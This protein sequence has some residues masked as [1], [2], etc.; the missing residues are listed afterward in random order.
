[1][2][3]FNGE[4]GR[5]EGEIAPALVGAWRRAYPSLDLSAELRKAEAWLMANP[6]RRKKDYVR[7]LGNW[8]AR[9][10]QPRQRSGNAIQGQ[11]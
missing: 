3:T 4:T 9:S 10:Y 11:R 8:L 7:F 2:I 5:L 1:M 6:K